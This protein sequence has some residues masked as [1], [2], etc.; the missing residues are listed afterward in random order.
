MLTPSTVSYQVYVNN[1]LRRKAMSVKSDVTQTEYENMDA[2]YD[3]ENK[4]MN[5][6]K[7]SFCI[8]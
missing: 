3:S 1:E 5:R 6:S 8:Q 4:Y 7:Q 2:D